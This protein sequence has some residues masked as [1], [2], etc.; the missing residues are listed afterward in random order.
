VSTYFLS[1]QTPMIGNLY[2]VAWVYSVVE[3]RLGMMTRWSF[4]A[5]LAL[6]V[7]LCC[8]QGQQVL[9]LLWGGVQ[10][11]SST[12]EHDPA[13]PHGNSEQVAHSSH[14][15]EAPSCEDGACEDGPCSGDTDCSCGHSFFLA[16]LPTGVTMDVNLVPSLTFIT[17][18]QVAQPAP[19]SRMASSVRAESAFNDSRPPT[20]LLRLHCALQV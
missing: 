4:A 17:F 6:S 19:L 14:G 8:C 2:E 11:H 20:S 1:F 9:G 10:S 15:T 12:N 16:V 5:L 13:A 7:S 18:S 3:M